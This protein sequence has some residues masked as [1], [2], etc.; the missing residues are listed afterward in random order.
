MIVVAV[1]GLL[2]G[3]L[4]GSLWF[5]PQ[6]SAFFTEFSGVALNVLILAVGIDI[7]QNKRYF[8][9]LRR[10][11]IRI[12]LI[13]LTTI[14]GS[15]AGGILASMLMGKSLR[16]GGAVGAGL[17]FYSVSALTV[18]DLI[19]PQAGTVTFLANVL[20][21]LFAIILAPCLSV[22]IS[23]YA[24]IS[25]A[26][27]TSMDTALPAISQYVNRE[28]LLISVFHGAVCTAAVPVLLPLLCHLLPT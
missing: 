1:A 27:A 18:N 8:V 13:P 6:I 20:R 14:T 19:S 17:A 26:G 23:P 2:L 25:A 22:Y 3:I 24:A 16:E 12:I 28:F 9:Q 7:G 10:Y 4:C 21:E 11:G 5:P 15:V